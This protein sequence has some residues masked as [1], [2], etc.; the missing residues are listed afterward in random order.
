MRE[1]LDQGRKVLTDAL[2]YKNKL[3]AALDAV[4]VV[5]DSYDYLS[6]TQDWQSDQ[7]LVGIEINRTQQTIS[8]LKA[9]QR[10]LSDTLYKELGGVNLSIKDNIV[11]ME[12]SKGRTAYMMNKGD[13][14]YIGVSRQPA[15]SEKQD[16]NNKLSAASKHYFNDSFKYVN[17]VI[18][19][20]PNQTVTVGK[21]NAIIDGTLS[22]GDR[23]TVE[24]SIGD[25]F[26]DQYSHD[27][28]RI[29]I[30]SSRFKGRQTDILSHNVS[31]IVFDDGTIANSA[32]NT[33]A[34]NGKFMVLLGGDG[35]D[36]YRVDRKDVLLN[37]W[38]TN[39]YDTVLT[40]VS[41]RLLGDQSFEKLSA[42]SASSKANIDLTGSRKTAVITGNAGDNVLTGS[43]NASYLN[44]R[45]GDDTLK[46]GFGLDTLVGGAGRDTFVFNTKL[47]AVQNVDTI[48]GFSVKDDA[49]HI[50]DK[51]FKGVGSAGAL[52]KG[53]FWSGPQAHDASDR[54][55]YDKATGALYYDQ[56]GFGP[57]QQVQFA[58]LSPGLKLSTSDFFVI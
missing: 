37:E 30:D 8:D 12:N 45:K 57:T 49:I 55:I 52:K 17:N 28:T 9:K 39:G 11:S 54:V 29:V 18:L 56:D 46:G 16:S 27:W 20:E 4:D 22:R 1:T 53:V 38:D 19:T 26:I 14:L 23:I 2:G 13:N 47:D 7:R 24:G 33:L 43:T 41:F 42:A 40:S 10:D 32:D 15:P 31:K 51:V 36:T 21:A 48:V 58:L 5:T 34:N 25:Y 35:N 3:T 44:G 6:R 50:D